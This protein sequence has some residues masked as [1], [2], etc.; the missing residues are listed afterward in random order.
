MDSWPLL[1]K[2]K[3]LNLLCELKELLN[4]SHLDLGANWQIQGRIHPPTR[5][6]TEV[7]SG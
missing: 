7:L 2:K 3:E 5:K 1:G 6:L 4:Y